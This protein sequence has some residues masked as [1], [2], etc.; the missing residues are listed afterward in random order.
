[1]MAINVEVEIVISDKDINDKTENSEE[2][3]KTNAKQ[4][5]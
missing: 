2:N 3:K 4:D 1:M 5:V